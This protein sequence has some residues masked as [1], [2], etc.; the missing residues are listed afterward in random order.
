MIPVRDVIEW[1]SYG[2]AGRTSVATVQAG[3]FCASG[4]LR[5]LKPKRRAQFQFPK[6]GV[7]Q[8]AT[9]TLVTVAMA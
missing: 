1:G 6:H 4:L 3:K 5:N 2:A 8:V 9:G 7:A